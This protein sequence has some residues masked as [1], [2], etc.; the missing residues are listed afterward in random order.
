[1]AQNAS[2]RISVK[3]R[4]MSTTTI[5]FTKND[6]SDHV[7]IFFDSDTLTNSLDK[8]IADDLLY[9]MT[10]HYLFQSQQMEKFVDEFIS[11]LKTFEDDGSK[12]A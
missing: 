7:E 10:V 5:T 6:D 2:Q 9:A 4:M 3:G 11:L 8:P 12:D 1:M